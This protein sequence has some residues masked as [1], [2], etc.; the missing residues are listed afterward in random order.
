MIFSLIHLYYVILGS[1]VLEY[2]FHQCGITMG[3]Q[4][5]QRESVCGKLDRHLVSSCTR[6]TKSFE[7][8]FKR[9]E[10]HSELLQI[11][12][13]FFPEDRIFT[14]KR[15]ADKHSHTVVA[16]RSFY[17]KS[18]PKDYTCHV[19]PVKGVELL[20]DFEM[21]CEMDKVCTMYACL[22]IF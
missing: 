6:E 21:T 2:E 18:K 1:T 11:K 22:Y 19:H 5:Y 10:Q 13:D 15:I 12:N 3:S 14:I 7:V 20:D 9:N 17:V 8:V 4:T 16:E